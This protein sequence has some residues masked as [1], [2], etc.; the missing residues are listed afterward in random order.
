V[1]LQ[2]IGSIGEL[3]GA[4]ATVGTLLY[5]AVQIRANTRTIRADARRSD[6]IAESAGY[7]SIVENAEVAERFQRGLAD[8]QSLDSR[9]R[10]RF[11]FL[12][13]PFIGRAQLEFLEHEEGMRDS[14]HF[15]RNLV[16][17][18]RFLRTPGG[19][20]FWMEQ[21]KSYHPSF[22]ACVD[23]WLSREFKN[24]GP[25]AAAHQGV[26]LDAR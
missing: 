21:E 16:S 15:D 6:I 20:D 24:T 10:I 19:R 11:S 13:A 2:D 17:R 26:E 7:A 1:T 14:V 22:E 3:V 4:I 12:L 23:D 8:L 25:Q 9:D 5:L 18:L